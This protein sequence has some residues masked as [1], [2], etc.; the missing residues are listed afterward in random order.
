[1]RYSNQYN[2]AVEIYRPLDILGIKPNMYEI[3]SIGNV[4]NKNT[5]QVLSQMVSYAQGGYRSIK[6]QMADGS[7]K[8]F[9]IH[10]LVALVFIPKTEEDIKLGRNT[11]NHIDCIPDHNEVC[12]LEWVTHNENI[13][14]GAEARRNNIPVYSSIFKGHASNHMYFGENYETIA[15]MQAEY[16]AIDSDTV[17]KVLKMLDKGY[18][19]QQVAD[20]MLNGNYYLASDIKQGKI[21]PNVVKQYIANKK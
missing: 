19:L 17:I 12:N 2:S 10:R 15:K 1:M 16:S 6:I 14:L 21:Y 18:T 20:K 11:I 8:T 4:R 13:R 3:S 7:A 9:P 5:G